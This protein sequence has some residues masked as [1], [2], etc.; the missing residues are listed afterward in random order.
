MIEIIPAIDMIDGR[1]V[2][3]TKGDYSKEKTYDA[4]PLE[5][6]LEYSRAGARRL[7]LVDLDGARSG[8]PRNLSVLSEILSRTPLKVEYGGGI[9]S[10]LSL[11]KVIAMGA[12]WAIVG[13]TAVTDPSLVRR[14]CGI[15]GPGRLILGV[16]FSEGK[17][18]TH[19]WMKTSD[20]T[21]EE[22][23]DSFPGIKDILCTDISRDGMLEG[24]DIGY[25]SS[26]Q[27]RYPDRV[28]SVSGGV[29]SEKDILLLEEAGLRSVIVGKAIYEGRI[30]LERLS[31]LYRRTEGK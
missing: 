9:R 19:G 4:S 8:E 3:L 11:E 10:T 29:S 26:L 20:L 6:A 7:H 17:V 28:I 14:W 2:R 13:S 30:S 18:A 23:M 24:V 5:M 27:E 25:Y 1:C 31:A 15:V 22:M 21:P 16:D 12:S